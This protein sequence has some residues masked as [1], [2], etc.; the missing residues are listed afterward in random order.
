[1]TDPAHD[2]LIPAEE[3]RR[4]FDRI[5]Q[6]YDFLN[7]LMSLGLHRFWR[8]RAV[9]S[10]CATS[11]AKGARDILDIGCGTGDIVIAV[12]RKDSKARVSGIDLSSLMLEIAKRKTRAAGLQS[13]ATYQVGDAT[14]LVFGNL[15]F[16]GIVSAFCL[17][18]IDN[19]AKAFQEMRRVMRPGGTLVILELT[20]PTARLLQLIHRFY[21]HRIIP[22]LGSLLSPGSAYRYLADS[23]EHFPPPAMITDEMA[24][25][26]FTQARYRPLTGGFVTLFTAQAPG[27]YVFAAPAYANSEPLAQFIP[28]ISPGSRVLREIPSQL[29]APLLAGTIDAA[30]IPIAA[31]FANPSLMAIGNVGI[32]AKNKVRSVLLRC[33][34]PIDQIR[35][36]CLDPASR[37]SNALALIL[38]EK[39]WKLS[40]Q[41]V[42]NPEEADANVVIGDRALC[43][44]PAPGG[45]YDL[46]TAWN[47]MTG[48]PFVFAVW[49]TRRDHAD[50]EGLSNV[51]HA[52]KQAGQAVIPGIAHQQAIKLG[53]SEAAFLEYF[54]D[55]IHYPI[56]PQERQAME[57]FREMQR[58]SPFSPLRPFLNVAGQ[59]SWPKGMT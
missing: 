18:N 13:R 45:D 27:P 25:A 51:I 17:R 50:P 29:L 38:L 57:L 39:F 40:V 31:I 20:K 10:L 56:G 19:R 2:A 11:Y 3:N 24:K 28:V 35:T 9:E 23:I 4:M 41:I 59:F 7:G 1:M 55:C 26:G 36:V 5:A 47:Q 12:L 44:A 22:W 21:T 15:A 48:L 16:D 42:S 37:T 49:V 30:L 52:A 14:S 8:H 34:R 58:D 32:C 6:H 54:T 43:E 33:N 53:L 46:A